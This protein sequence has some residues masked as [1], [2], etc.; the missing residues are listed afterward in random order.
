[1]KGRNLW[2]PII[3]VVF[4]TAGSIML[5]ALLVSSANLASRT[6]DNSANYWNAF[7]RVITATENPPALAGRPIT[8]EQRDALQVYGEHLRA[9]VGDRPTC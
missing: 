3:A 7:Q 4:M 5:V 6:C 8:Q 9:A 1:M 2:V